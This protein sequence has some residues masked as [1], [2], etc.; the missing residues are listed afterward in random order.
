[1]QTRAVLEV[2]LADPLAEHYGLEICR[3]VGLP[4]GTIYPLLARLEEAGWLRS[5]WEDMAT[6]AAEKR[7]PRRYYRLTSD[8]IEYA[9]QTLAEATRS[10]TSRP[11]PAPWLP[12]PGL[13]DPK[14]SPA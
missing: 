13:P 6:A 12:R 5:G 9:Q 4:S 8:G 11:I 2:L 7:R 10:I 1:M 14:Q 3:V